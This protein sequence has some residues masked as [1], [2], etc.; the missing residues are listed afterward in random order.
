MSNPNF[1]SASQNNSIVLNGLIGEFKTLKS[2]VKIKYFST[3][4]NSKSD[5]DFL[6]ELKPMREKY[7][8]SDINDIQSI[9]QRDVNDT[10]IAQEI[11]PYLLNE[12]LGKSSETHLPFFPSIMAVLLPKN[13]ILSNIENYP[14]SSL[15]QDSPNQR[16]LSY[17]DD[18]WQIKEYL[19]EGQTTNFATLTVNKS[20]VDMLVVDGQH[21]AN[22]FRAVT[23]KFP[24]NSVYEIYYDKVKSTHLIP[25][26]DF[27]ADLPV[28]ILW[29]ERIDDT[30]KL[31]PREIVRNLFV[32]VNNGAKQIGL[33]RSILLNDVL[34]NNFLTNSFYNFLLKNHKFQINKLS[35]FHFGL[36]YD[37]SLSDR[38]GFGN[39][40]LFVPEIV[41]FAFNFFYFNN[42]R[43]FPGKSSYNEIKNLNKD[44]D[45]FEDYFLSSANNYFHVIEDDYE[46]FHIT[47]TDE[48]A[49]KS[50]GDYLALHDSEFQR[51]YNII[52]NFPIVQKYLE[53]LDEL[54]RD[55]ENKK[56][57]FQSPTNNFKD[58]FD[59]IISSEQ[60]L[61]FSL[62]ELPKTAFV[63]G[64]YWELTHDIEVKFCAYYLPKQNVNGV[65]DSYSFRTAVDRLRTKVFFIGILAACE[66]FNAYHGYSLNSSNEFIAKITQ[67]PIEKWVKCFDAFWGRYIGELKPLKW[68]V[69]SSLILRVLQDDND[70]YFTNNTSNSPDAL[71]LKV[72]LEE[73]SRTYVKDILHHTF[74]NSLSI[75]EFDIRTVNLMFSDRLSQ[76]ELFYNTCDMILIDFP[77]YENFGW[78]Y[79]YKTIKL[80]LQDPV[81]ISHVQKRNLLNVNLQQNKVKGS[82]I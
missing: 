27:D 77:E 40:D 7:P 10:R 13:F 31:N 57:H 37:K 62:S 43:Y 61:Y 16:I 58:A 19:S 49:R 56:N 64:N 5:I 33:S 26:S 68:P 32:S 51:I 22:A 18:N 66:Q 80:D 75:D 81:C 72:E 53:L 55:I 65:P 12:V 25:S 6:D 15:S 69:V 8:V 34:P 38:K 47:F 70:L 23:G 36:D 79:I 54:H 50:L 48:D 29:F 17:G 46:N 82:G 71:M 39:F 45:V 21:R 42:N 24:Q 44:L 28:T 11:L 59:K 73:A 35:L 67:V 63:K 3:K 52:S 76:L 74:D 60:G 78:N 9:I 20:N 1:P 14:D 30:V 4:A 41:D 2:K